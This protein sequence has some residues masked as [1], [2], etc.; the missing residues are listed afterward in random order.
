MSLRLLETDKLV[1]NK[2]KAEGSK[3]I[4]TRVQKARDMQIKRFKG[5]KF[6]SNSEMSSKA[7]KE[8]CKLSPE[9]YAI[10]RSAVASM[11]LTA[12]SYHKVIKV[13]RTIA[14]LEGVE[15]ITTTHIAEA[16]QYRPKEE[17]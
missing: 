13:A 7:I 1:G 15:V 9:C 4:Q 12:R 14:D 10:L 8:F 11:N 16:L 17:D 6:K 5:S 2:E 3:S